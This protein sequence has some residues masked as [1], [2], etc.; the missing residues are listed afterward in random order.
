MSSRCP[1][2]AKRLPT[3]KAVR[4][5]VAASLSCAKSWEMD[6]LEKIPTKT[7]TNRSLHSGSTSPNPSDVLIDDKDSEMDGLAYDFVLE[8]EKLANPRTPSPAPVRVDPPVN[9]RPEDH[10]V[11]DQPSSPTRYSEAYPRSAGRPIRKEKT[12]FE[13]FRDTDSDAGR[14][15][16]EPFLSKKE[17]ELATWMLKNVNQ[18]ATN[19]Y[20]NLPI[21]SFQC[22]FCVSNSRDDSDRSRMMGTSRSIIPTLF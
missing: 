15:P 10:N 13:K 22:L 8:H 20:L 12:E 11:D 14:Q 7:K 5:H 2:C 16:W 17:W 1:Y 21:V 9:M 6:Q 4:Q 3:G 19:Q 18:R